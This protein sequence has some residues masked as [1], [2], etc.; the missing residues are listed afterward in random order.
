MSKV[1]VIVPVYNNSEYL[2]YAIL[3]LIQQSRVPDEI[4]VSDDGSSEDIEQLLISLLDKVNCKLIY[5]KQ[6]DNGFRLAKCKNNGARVATGDILIFNDQDIISTRNYIRQY[7]EHVSNNSFVVAY[8]VRLF[9]S[10]N[11]KIYTCIENNV[12]RYPVKLPQRY[13][14]FR[15]FI[16]DTISNYMKTILSSKAYKPKLRG[17]VFGITKDNFYRVNGFD[18]NFSGWGREDDDLG[19]RLNSIRIYGET[20]FLLDFPLHLY[21]P[22]N[23]TQKQSLNQEYYNKRSKEIHKGDYLARNGI[24]NPLGNEELYIN[25]LN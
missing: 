8:P 5:V 6:S 21:H 19:R 11:K 1:S 4:V 2:R 20:V 24:N 22:I 16:K 14:I 12:L 7:A 13:K 15:Q 9:K 17:G 3:C 25:Y 23:K 10:Q 18:E